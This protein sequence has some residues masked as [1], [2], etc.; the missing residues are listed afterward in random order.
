LQ[1]SH[2]KNRGGIFHDYKDGALFF[3]GS[4][5]DDLSLAESANGCPEFGGQGDQSFYMGAS[6]FPFLGCVVGEFDL[7]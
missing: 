5:H 1:K 7:Y 4:S 2:R 3:F 6:M